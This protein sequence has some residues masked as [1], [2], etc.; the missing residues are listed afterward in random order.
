[1]VKWQLYG[2]KPSSIF[3][4]ALTPFRKMFLSRKLLFDAQILFKRLPSFGVPKLTA[5]LY[6]VAVNI[7]FGKPEKNLMKKRLFSKAFSK[8]AKRESLVLDIFVLQFSRF[9]RPI[10]FKRLNF[11]RYSVHN[12]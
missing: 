7:H 6:E 9:P 2:Q 5:I 11:T 8:H 3:E 4:K 10:L 12:S 1:M